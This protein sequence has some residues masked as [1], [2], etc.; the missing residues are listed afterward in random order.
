MVE[1][2]G[3][4]TRVGVGLQNKPLRSIF[5]PI[6]RLLQSRLVSSHGF[7]NFLEN[8]ILVLYCSTVHISILAPL[9]TLLYILLDIALAY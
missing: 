5:V 2:P 9:Y 1:A 7:F 6:V 8:P 4:G 3:G